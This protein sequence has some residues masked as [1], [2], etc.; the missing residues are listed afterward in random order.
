MNSSEV[1]S[2][3]AVDLSDF[4]TSDVIGLTPSDVLELRFPYVPEF[5]Q[6]VTVQPDGYVSLR[7]VGDLRVAGRTCRSSR[8]C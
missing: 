7:V 3:N 4:W 5:D 6:T 8:R 2:R 1:A